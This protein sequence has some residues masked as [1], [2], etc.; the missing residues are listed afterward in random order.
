MLDKVAEQTKVLNYPEAYSVNAAGRWKERL[1]TYPG[2][3]HGRDQRNKT[4]AV[5]VE[6][7]FVMRSQQR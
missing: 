4:F 6:T 1:R 3:P 7:R 5:V 2:R